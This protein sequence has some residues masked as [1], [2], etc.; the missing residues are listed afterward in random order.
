LTDASSG[1]RLNH[2]ANLAA[3][4]A[5]ADSLLGEPLESLAGRVEENFLHLFGGL[6]CGPA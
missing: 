1:K 6:G 2:P 4:Y 3:V 5:F